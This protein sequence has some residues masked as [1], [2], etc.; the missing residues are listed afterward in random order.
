MIIPKGDETQKG[1]WIGGRQGGTNKRTALITCPKCGQFVS[2]STH[3]IADNG[4]VT[5]SLVCPHYGCDFH[6]NVTL[7]DWSRVSSR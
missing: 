2:L 4:D 3:S 7:A 1:T 5:P 6:E